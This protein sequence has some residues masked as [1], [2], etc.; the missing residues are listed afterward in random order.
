MKNSRQVRWSL[1]H[2][3][4]QRRRS[5]RNKWREKEIAQHVHK[6]QFNSKCALALVSFLLVPLLCAQCSVVIWSHR[7]S[8]QFASRVRIP[9]GTHNSG[10]GMNEALNQLTK[11]VSR[12]GLG[13]RRSPPRTP[14][15][16]VKCLLAAPYHCYPEQTD[17]MWFEFRCPV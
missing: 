2:V 5:E 1:N 9:S 15:H 7:L 14:I 4:E 12:I 8:L 11:V 16:R 6:M 10:R 13:Y 3:S 17:R